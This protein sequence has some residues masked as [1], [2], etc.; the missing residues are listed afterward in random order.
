MHACVCGV[1]CGSARLDP[2][3][4]FTTQTGMTAMTSTAS[5]LD[6]AHPFTRALAAFALLACVGYVALVAFVLRSVLTLCLYTLRSRP[7]PN[8][9]DRRKSQPTHDVHRQ[10][11]RHPPRPY[12]EPAAHTPPHR[13]HHPNL[14]AAAPPPP[15]LHHHR[16][17]PPPHGAG[18][19]AGGAGLGRAHQGD[20][21][22]AP[23][24]RSG[25]VP[26][27][28]LRPCGCAST[29]SLV[30]TGV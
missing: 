1:L 10:A 15:T 4:L 23:W 27:R 16:N 25:A 17:P 5:L 8:R 7:K 12:Q 19:D 18:Q 29:L 9:I 24:A 14:P 26:P 11:L 13:H 6:P 21:H 22:H 20:A 3:L 28:R 30:S 2:L